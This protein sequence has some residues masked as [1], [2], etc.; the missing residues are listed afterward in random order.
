M[1]KEYKGEPYQPRKSAKDKRIDA[2]IKKG[3]RDANLMR[4]KINALE[5]VFGPLDGV[6]KG[7]GRK[8]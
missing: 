7:K 1:P 3:L 2:E 4:Q 5:G 8:K 6:R